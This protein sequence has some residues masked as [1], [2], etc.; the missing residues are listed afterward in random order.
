MIIFQNNNI[1]SFVIVTNNNNQVK[2][3]AERL[4]LIS[5]KEFDYWV[6]YNLKNLIM[7]LRIYKKKKI[8]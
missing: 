1:P 8:R 5:L 6:S 2:C 7:N 3:L 4:R